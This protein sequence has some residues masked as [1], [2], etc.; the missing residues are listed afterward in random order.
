MSWLRATCD[1]WRTH[2]MQTFDWLTFIVWYWILNPIMPA[3][4]NKVKCF[5]VLFPCSLSTWAWSKTG[6][7]CKIVHTLSLFCAGDLKSKGIKTQI[8]HVHIFY[9]ESIKEIS[10]ICPI[11]SYKATALSVR[12]S[13]VLPVY[14]SKWRSSFLRQDN[15]VQNCF[16]SLRCAHNWYWRNKSW[17]IYGRL[18][19]IQGS[20]NT[21]IFFKS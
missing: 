18:T 12:R 17:V 6:G 20:M 3:G 8:P 13:D 5:N 9:M 11:I 15:L 2:Q 21:L 1:S 16:S 7:L 14:S 19:A 4:K 10:I